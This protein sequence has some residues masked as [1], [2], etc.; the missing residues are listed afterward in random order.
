MILS[1]TVC[2]SHPAA[3]SGW[4]GQVGA[5]KISREVVQDSRTRRQMTPPYTPESHVFSPAGHESLSRVD[6]VK[7]VGKVHLCS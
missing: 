6:D 7:I 5:L 1:A 2:A 3:E 4:E